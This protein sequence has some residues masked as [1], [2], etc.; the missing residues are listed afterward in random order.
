MSGNVLQH[1]DFEDIDIN[2]F[3]DVTLSANNT[4]QAVFLCAQREC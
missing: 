3:N 4:Q 2:A 1:A